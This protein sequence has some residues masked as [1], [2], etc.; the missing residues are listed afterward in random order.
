MKCC[1]SNQIA[2][3]YGILHCTILSDI[4]CN[5]ERTLEWQVCWINTVNCCTEGF[6]KYYF[7]FFFYKLCKVLLE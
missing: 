2:V 6:N 3:S 1:S 5:L 4:W 7:T